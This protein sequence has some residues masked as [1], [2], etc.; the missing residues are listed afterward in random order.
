MVP[1][2][3]QLVPIF[4]HLFV[5]TAN[6]QCIMSYGLSIVKSVRTVLLI[7]FF[8]FGC[9]LTSKAQYEY[10]D[11][12]L[13]RNQINTAKTDSLRSRLYGILGWEMR[14]SNQP[15]AV[16][17]ADSMILVSTVS[18]DYIRLAEAY[19]IKGFVKVVNQDIEGCLKMYQQGIQ[20]AKKAK[21]KYY[22]SAIL[23]LI[24]GMYQDKGDFDQSIQFFFRSQQS[25]RRK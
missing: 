8:C 7:C 21:S 24:A 14:F 4:C 1:K 15:K 11:T 3:P 5:F 18:K 23:N 9:L 16:E 19:R 17:L 22:E 10:V 25:C 20:F 2:I 12:V 13:I 6:L